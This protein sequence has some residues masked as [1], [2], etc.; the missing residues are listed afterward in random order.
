[1]LRVVILCEAKSQGRDEY[2]TISRELIKPYTDISKDIDKELKSLVEEFV[3]RNDRSYLADYIPTYKIRYMDN[4]YNGGED[5]E[6][7]DPL[8]VEE[9]VEPKYEYTLS[10]QIRNKLGTHFQLCNFSLIKSFVITPKT[11]ILPS[12][13]SGI[14]GYYIGETYT[15]PSIAGIFN[16]LVQMCNGSGACYDL[17]LKD[18]S[19]YSGEID[20]HAI[21]T[22]TKY[23]LFKTLNT[24]Y[25]YALGYVKCED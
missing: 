18:G 9:T 17:T 21:F 13:I 4:R 2:L 24:L 19:T 14:Y 8:I 15:L 12:D 16:S 6:N 25:T 23:D 1:M 5:S 20:L 3:I 11:V 22:D 10:K 7:D